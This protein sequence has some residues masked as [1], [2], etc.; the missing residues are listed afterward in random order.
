[1]GLPL[2]NLS[3]EP[4]DGPTKAKLNR[5]G[6]EEIGG[7]SRADWFRKVLGPEL[8]RSWKLEKLG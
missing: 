2:T 4:F 1:M 5:K 8:F 7:Q 6:I 3:G